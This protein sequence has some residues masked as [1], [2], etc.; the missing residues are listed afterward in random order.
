M[1]LAGEVGEL[2]ELFQWLTPEESSRVMEDPGRAESVRQELA[3]VMVYIIR[4]LDSLEIDI[5]QAIW[6]KLKSN[7]E[8]YPV[9][10]VKGK[11]RKYT[12]L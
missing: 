4:L 11:A 7:T 8:K 6:K 10:Q 12:D 5:E 9:S 3:D 1:A 2:T